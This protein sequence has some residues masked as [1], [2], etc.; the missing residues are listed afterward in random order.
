MHTSACSL[1]TLTVRAWRAWCS[2]SRIHHLVRDARTQV[3]DALGR[4]G[5]GVSMNRIGALIRWLGSGGSG[6]EVAAGSDTDTDADADADA[7]AAGTAAG[8]ASTH[9]ASLRSAHARAF[10]FYQVN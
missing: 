4:G 6:G 2:C 9:R 8:S 5:A 7:D 10:Y 3:S 1:H